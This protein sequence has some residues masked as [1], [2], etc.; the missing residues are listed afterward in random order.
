MGEDEEAEVKAFTAS[1]G[2]TSFEAA[3]LLEEYGRNELPE[4]NKP[5]VVSHHFQLE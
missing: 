3:K 2:L 5:K 4:K 1:Q